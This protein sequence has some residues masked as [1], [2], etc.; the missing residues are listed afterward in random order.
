[1]TFEQLEQAVTETRAMVQEIHRFLPATLT[2]EDVA[3]RYL[4]RSLRW[5]QM[6]PWSLP[7][8]DPENPNR[9]TVDACDDY[10]RGVPEAYRCRPIEYRK[11]EYYRGH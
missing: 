9:W 2:A 11:E 10:Y 8:Q 7:P 4:G 5:A 1:M 3:R 6:R